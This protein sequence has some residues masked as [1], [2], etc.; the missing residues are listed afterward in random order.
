MPQ[1]KGQFIKPKQKPLPNLAEEI[2]NVV[3]LVSDL[4]KIKESVV[5]TVDTK[6][7]EVDDK[8]NDIQNE[9]EQIKNIQKGEDG[10]DAALIS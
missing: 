3:N 10:K 8:I 7:N 9:F 1:I 6:L 4:N 2:G 5:E